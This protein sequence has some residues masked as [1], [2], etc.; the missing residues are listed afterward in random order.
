MITVQLA[1]L[2]VVRLRIGSARFAGVPV[3]ASVLLFVV[4]ARRQGG[5]STDE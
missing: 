4:R 3:V 5:R 1:V 2:T